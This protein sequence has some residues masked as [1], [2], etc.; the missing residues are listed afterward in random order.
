MSLLLTLA[1]AEPAVLRQE[2]V[3]TAAREEQPRD[4]AS[5]AVTVLDREEIKALPATSLAEVLSYLPGVTMYFESGANGLPAITSRGF[6]GGGEVEYVKLLVDGV[7]V[8]DAESGIVDWQRFRAAGIE[9]IEL[10][11]GPGSALYGDT[12][13][14]GVIQVFTRASTPGQASGEIRAGT[15]SFGA[16]E[17]HASYRAGVGDGIRLDISGGKWQTGGYR[18]NSDADGWLGQLTLERIGDHARWRIDAGGDRQ[19]R[20]QPGALT[21]DELAADREQSNAA[22]R[23][24]GQTTQR[25]RA[26]AA[27][28]SFGEIPL[29]ATLYGIHRSDDNLRT[30]LLA[31]GFG[32][33]AFRTLTTRAGGGTFEASRDWTRGTL[34][35]GAD[36]ERATLSARYASVDEGETGD[37]VAAADGRRDRVGLFVTGGWTAG[38]RYR[39]TAGVRR[40]EV[41]DDV[42]SQRRSSAWSPRAGVNVHL[43]SAAA[44]LSLFLQLSHAFKAPTLDQLFDP[45]PYPD[46]MGGTFT[47]SNPELRPQRAQNVEAGLSRATVS[48]NW[49]V[50]AY[51][52]KVRDEIDF[53]PQ[54]FTYRNIGSSVH[55]GVETS[56]RLAKTKRVSPEVTY[57]WT[58]V[59]D[60]TTP[61]RQLKNIPEHTAQLLLHARLS[62]RTRASAVYR[63]RSSLTLDDEAT[64]RTPS[65]SRVDL[66]LAHEVGNA[67][68]E[69]DVLNALDARY[70]ELGYVLI[71]FDGRPLPF[72]YPAPGRAVRLGVTWLFR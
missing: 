63:W 17:L 69:A 29:R 31:P 15:G 7:P 4:Q 47:I 16:G 8:G 35:A 33:S 50:V 45:R 28:D 32:A 11:H 25:A 71:D 6:F 70:S 44:P 49:S 37:T 51:R 5:A 54:T 46:G 26:G 24:D 27:F 66:R 13:L 55:R 34:R 60:G 62:G 43:G 18:D 41:R 72:E 64:F 38:E 19:E 59:A 39:F 12:A 14:G 42:T 52:M 56:L 58:R 10:L 21:R 68:F 36:L 30:L 22:F 2:I 40:D 57:S 48:S 61:D 1:A 9:R 65:V 67:R 20:H 53:D 3:V 23:F